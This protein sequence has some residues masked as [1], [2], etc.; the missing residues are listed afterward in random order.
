[1]IKHLGLVRRQELSCNINNLNN[2]RINEELILKNL[3]HQERSNSLNN[4]PVLVTKHFQCKVE[5]NH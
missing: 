3:S 1:M 2:L 4:N 5:A